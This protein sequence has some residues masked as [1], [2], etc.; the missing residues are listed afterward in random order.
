MNV[1]IYDVTFNDN[2]KG[3]I[4]DS[5]GILLTALF[6]DIQINSFNHIHIFNPSLRDLS[7]FFIFFFHSLSIYD[8]NIQS[9][10]IDEIDFRH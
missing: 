2:Q 4:S 1:V 10:V 3:K 8:Q 6:W 7:D 9:L 5:T